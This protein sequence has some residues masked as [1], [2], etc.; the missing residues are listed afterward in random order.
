MVCGENDVLAETLAANTEF[1][2]CFYAL[3]GT[4]PNAESRTGRIIAVSTDALPAHAD[5]IRAHCA[6]PSAP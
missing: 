3:D 2:D 6:A 1:V 5:F 4:A